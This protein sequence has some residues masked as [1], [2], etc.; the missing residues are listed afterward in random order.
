MKATMTGPDHNARVQSQYDTKAEAYL[1]STVH[2]QGA[3]LQ[4]LAELARQ[5]PQARALDVGCGGG[6]VSFTLAPRMREVVAYDLSAPML[7]T[8]AREAKRRG[9]ANLHTRQGAAEHLDE[10][11]DSFD[12]VATRFSAHHWQNFAAGLQ[13]MARVLKPGGTGVFMDVVSPGAPLLDTWLQ[14]V[15]LLR[16]PSHVRDASL[17]EWHAA[18]AAAGL[19]V[20]EQRS[21]RLHLEFSSLIA[22]MQPPASHVQAIRSLQQLASAPVRTHFALQDDGGFTVDTTLLVAR[23]GMG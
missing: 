11:A 3:D 2:A 22:R 6:H 4:A 16:D 12:L 19:T 20:V 5:W 15:E 9:L 1:A 14:T 10:P 13:Q 7:D 8:V 18:L 17:A 23:K 21:A